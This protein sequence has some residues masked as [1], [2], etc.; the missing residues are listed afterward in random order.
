MVLW[1]NSTTESERFNVFKLCT[2]SQTETEIEMRADTT[3]DIIRLCHKKCDDRNVK[4]FRFDGGAGK[5]LKCLKLLTVFD[6]N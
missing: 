2:L 6:L 4:R 3:R 5:Y 1:C